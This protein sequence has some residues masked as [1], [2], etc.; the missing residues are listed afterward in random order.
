MQ[1]KAGECSF[2]W[3]NW[4]HLSND[5]LGVSKKRGNPQI[6]HLNRVFHYKPSILRYPYFWKHPFATNKKKE[7][8]EIGEFVQHRCSNLYCEPILGWKKHVAIRT[9]QWRKT[10][11]YTCRASFFFLRACKTCCF[12]YL[13]QSPK[14]PKSSSRYNRLLL[15]LQL[16]HS[17]YF[18]QPLMF[19]DS[20]TP[21][22]CRFLISWSNKFQ[23]EPRLAKILQGSSLASVLR[24]G[25]LLISL[26]ILLEDVGVLLASLQ[27][28][29]PVFL[30]YRIEAIDWRWEETL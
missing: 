29:S 8:S 25:W 11:L 27:A 15:W 26:E 28:T 13:C 16:Y 12:L 9:W 20:L 30:V 2:L 19:N 21:K 17:C 5:Y 23:S 22:F 14:I 24:K 6:I 10:W 3:F 1:W 4:K 7:T 18:P